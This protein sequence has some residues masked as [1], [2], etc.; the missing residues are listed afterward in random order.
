MFESSSAAVPGLVALASR[1]VALSP[2]TG[3]DGGPGVDALRLLG[4]VLAVL[5]DLELQDLGESPLVEVLSA[6]ESVKNAL[7]GLQARAG[8]VLDERVRARQEAAG[9]EREKLGAGVH[10]QIALARSESPNTGHRLLGLAKAVVNEMPH[11]NRALATGRLSEW[12]ATMLV[13]ESACL[14]REERLVLDEQLLADPSVLDGVGTKTLVARARKLAYA[15]S[16]AAVAERARRAVKD[17]RVSLR[18]APDTMSILTGLLPVVEGVSVLKALTVEADRLVGVGD[19]RSRGQIMADT[20]VERVT[21]QQ[22]AGRVRLEVQVV[23]TD[24][25]LF[26]GDAEPAVLPG[27]G[28]VPGQVGR[29]LV[30]RACGLDV[31]ATGAGADHAGG[32][33][34][35]DVSSGEG[36]AWMRRL[37]TAPG[38]GELVGMDSR[39]RFFPTGLARFIATRDQMCATAWCDAPIR[40]NDH[41]YPWAAGGKT[42]SENANGLCADCNH[43]KEAPGWGAAT[44]PG[45]RHTTVTTTPTGHVYRSQAPPLPGDTS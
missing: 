9:V 30:R 25:T 11:T 17:R 15:A 39:A 43:V 4:D 13:R 45:D 23:M 38:T 3:L 31:P 8:V 24:R 33:D 35:A 36:L 37:Y 14:T 2:E 5:P 10:A 41:I 21:G 42:T 20:L 28:V 44:A 32:S 40:Q 34:P 27:Y 18:P 1:P 19:G 16:P 12:R 7:A 29:D 22:V 26:Q 6:A